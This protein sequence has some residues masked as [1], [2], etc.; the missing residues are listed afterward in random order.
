L[1]YHAC[2]TT[3]KVLGSDEDD[4]RAVLPFRNLF[5]SQLG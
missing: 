5:G 2:P 1:S 4:N 3:G